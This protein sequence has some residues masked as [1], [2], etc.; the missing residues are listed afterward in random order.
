[1]R[2]VVVL[3]TL[4][5]RKFNKIS[6]LIGLIAPIISSVYFL[7]QIP[8]VMKGQ[9]VSVRIPWLTLIDINLDF[10]LD[11]LSLFF[12]LLIS[13]IGLA[14]FY[15]ATQHLSKEHDHLPCF[16][17]YLLLFMFS[18]LGI[19]T[20]N[21]TI[22]MYVF[23]ELTS[24]SSF[25]LIAY[26][27]D[28]GASQFGA[29]QSFIITV[30]GGLALLTGFIMIYTVTGTNSISSIIAQSDKIAESNLFI[31]IIIM[32]LLG[33]FTKSAQFPFHI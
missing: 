9:F 19:V 24:V 3:L 12:S 16:Y 21:N 32:L 27:Y 15:H 10:N 29:I 25:L 8:Q 31:P 6:G 1:L 18:M 22:L 4:T 20:S 28:K 14:V 26:W 30:F 33:A 13:I 5:N 7:W 11:G 23:W 2:M 17:I